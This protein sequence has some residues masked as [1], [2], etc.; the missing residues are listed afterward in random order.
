MALKLCM[1]KV[2]YLEMRVFFHELSES[3]SLS[4]DQTYPRDVAI[5]FFG[6]VPLGLLLAFVGRQPLPLMA[7]CAACFL[8]SLSIEVGQLFLIA[9]VASTSDLLLNML[10]GC[11]GTW[12]GNRMRRIPIRVDDG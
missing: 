7:A 12:L 8:V 2:Y 1:P 10:G 5:N 9:R 4:P 6:F 3:V 11:M